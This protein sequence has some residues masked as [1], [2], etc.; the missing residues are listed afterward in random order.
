MSECSTKIGMPQQKWRLRVRKFDQL[1]S[2]DLRWFWMKFCELV[3]P[4]GKLEPNLHFAS[5]ILPAF[6]L[7]RC[8]LDKNNVAIWLRGERQ[9]PDSR[10]RNQPVLTDRS[11]ISVFLII[12]VGEGFNSFVSICQGDCLS[13]VFFIFY[14]SNALL[15]NLQDTAIAEE[16]K[17]RYQICST[18]TDLTNDTL[19]K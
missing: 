11:L 7:N 18:L 17:K 9:P 15:N 4:D 12:E 14:L 1:T 16:L 10:M 6:V 3:V 8:D 19:I 2:Y 5:I 13:A